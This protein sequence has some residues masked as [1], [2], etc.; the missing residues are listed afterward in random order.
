MPHFTALNFNDGPTRHPTGTLTVTLTGRYSGSVPPD[1]IIQKIHSIL[2]TAQ[3]KKIYR[4]QTYYTYYIEP[5]TD[6]DLSPLHLKTF[7]EVAEGTDALCQMTA[8]ERRKIHLQWVPVT[9]TETHIKQ[10]AQTFTRPDTPIDFLPRRYGTDDRH[11][12][13]AEAD[14]QDIPHYVRVS[15]CGP[16]TLSI[17]VTIPGRRI[18]CIHCARDDHYSSKCPAGKP[19]QTNDAPT[20]TTTITYADRLKNNPRQPH[21]PTTRRPPTDTAT[22]TT[23]ATTPAVDT[24]APALNPTAPTTQTVTSTALLRSPTK[25]PTKTQT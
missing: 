16:D 10:I 21:Q 13:L 18:A 1:T 14:E 19:E 7:R 17:L 5:Q 11:I 4:L 3:I 15:G 23:A 9:L 12:L 2:P 6:T 20:T 22:A 25:T 24:P 8:R